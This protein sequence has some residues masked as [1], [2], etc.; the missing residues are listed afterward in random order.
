MG[1]LLAGYLAF[2]A[3]RGPSG[4]SLLVSGW[5]AASF[6]LAAAALCFT[7]GVTQRPGRAGALR[8]GFRSTPAALGHFA[9]TAGGGAGRAR[10]GARPP[11]RC[12]RHPC[13]KES[14]A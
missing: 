6:E 8:L 1:V 7:R 3:A 10:A 11:R 13:S 14:S 12:A 2:L 9:L 5:G 4:N